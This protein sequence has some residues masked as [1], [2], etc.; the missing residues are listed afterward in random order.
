ME[1]AAKREKKNYIK[2][3]LTLLGH[4]EISSNDWLKAVRG[5]AALN[6][7]PQAFSVRQCCVQH[8]LNDLES[9]SKNRSIASM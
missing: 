2:T 6:A 3:T 9:R 5:P 4:F 8:H 7:R 1:N